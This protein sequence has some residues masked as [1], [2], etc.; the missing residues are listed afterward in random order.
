MQDK[1]SVEI[2]INASGQQQI[3]QYKKA[4]DGLRTSINNLCNPINKL[5]GEISNYPALKVIK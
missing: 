5:N 3:A 4:F 2:E 1:I